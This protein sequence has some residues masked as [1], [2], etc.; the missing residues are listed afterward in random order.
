MVPQ[1]YRKNNKSIR[2]GSWTYL[3]VVDVGVAEEAI[4]VYILQVL[5]N[6]KVCN[7]RET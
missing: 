3:G 4:R 7:Q 6:L 5:E 2:E 1:S